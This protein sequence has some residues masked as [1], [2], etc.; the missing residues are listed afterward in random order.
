[1]DTLRRA[2]SAAA[3]NLRFSELIAGKSTVIRVQQ[4][5]LDTMKV[6]DFMGAS[7]SWPGAQIADSLGPIYHSPKD[8]SN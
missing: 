5:V 1:M 4:E 2:A 8:R 7:K 6:E 3:I